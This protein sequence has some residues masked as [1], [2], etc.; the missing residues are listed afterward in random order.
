MGNAEQ[1]TDWCLTRGV[2]E[3]LCCSGRL[4]LGLL[5][6]WHVDRQ[7]L[8]LLG[9]W[10]ET[11]AK[12]N[13]GITQ[14]RQTWRKVPKSA[15]W[16]LCF[17]VELLRVR[18]SWMIH[19]SPCSPS[20]FLYICAIY[21]SSSMT[22]PPLPPQPLYPQTNNFLSKNLTEPQEQPEKLTWTLLLQIESLG[23][24]VDYKKGRG[25]H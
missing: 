23:S 7:R 20:H 1:T 2:Y 4:F 11:G 8:W 13:R 21:W 12:E 16:A 24:G 25:S 9:K 19:Y 14:S 18:V 10:V 15:S 3:E 6:P 22:P 5:Q 17:R